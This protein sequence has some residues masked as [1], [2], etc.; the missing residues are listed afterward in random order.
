MNTPNHPAKAMELSLFYFSGK[1]DTG[2]EDRYELLAEGARFADRNGFAAVWTPER[3]F[4]DFG[5]LFPNP[6]VMGAFLAAIT[7]RI[8]IRAG[9]LVL[10]LHSPIRAAEEWALVDCLSGGR[11]GV[12][13]ASGWHDRDFVLAPDRYRDR[14]EN[15]FRQIE[16]VRSLWRGESIRL[17]NGAGKETEV[18]IYPR[19]IQAEIPIWLTARG[20]PETF[21]KAGEMGANILTHLLGQ[22]LAE[23]GKKIAIY[24]EARKSAGLDPSAGTVT[25]MLHTFLG[26][27]VDQ[28]REIVRRPFSEYLKSAIDLRSQLAEDQPRE[29]GVRVACESDRD[30][31]I[32]RGFDRYFEASGL[33]GTPE[34]CLPKIGRLR[35][36]GV[37]EVA[38]LI[39]FGVDTPLV[40][41]SFEALARLKELAASGLGE[42][43]ASQDPAVA[44]I[45]AAART[46]VEKKLAEI[47]TEV[48]QEGPVGIHDNFFV[49]GGHSLHATRVISRINHELAVDLALSEIYE[50][51]TIGELAALIDRRQPGQEAATAEVGHVLSKLEALSEEDAEKILSGKTNANQQKPL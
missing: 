26:D 46:R 51:P 38:C 13:F 12:S 32:A 16:M 42:E 4:H 34:S 48:L 23:L 45:T 24:R 14:K 20:D 47:W 25:L 22:N 35:R 29:A 3:H 31:V 6:S 27:S 28:V 40:I 33:F 7:D 19:P 50:H 10:P 2:V 9:S 11:T 49:H 5:G 15:L 8:D 41:R 30:T 17:P 21:R 18:R 36:I 1:A 43:E 39:D 37:T 44:E